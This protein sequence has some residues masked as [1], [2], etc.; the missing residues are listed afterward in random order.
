MKDEQIQV[1]FPFIIQHSSFNLSLR[2]YRDGD[3]ADLIR[4]ANNPNVAHHLRDLFPQPY[5][6]AGADQWIRR[7]GK[8]QPALNLAICRE[9]ELIGG[10]GLMP[11][12]DIHRASAEIGYWLG[13]SFWGRGIATAAVVNLVHYAFTTFPELNRL[14][15]YV[16][17]EHLASQRV[18]KKAH[19]R[20]E[21]HLLGG[22]IKHGKLRNQFLYGLTRAEAAR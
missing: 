22:A 9:D 6:W 20:R 10:I 8:E 7:A 4:H 14:F 13:E 15:A 11:G 21:G 16:D 12:S 2:P 1:C 19:F 3:Q 5:T 18:L 17:E